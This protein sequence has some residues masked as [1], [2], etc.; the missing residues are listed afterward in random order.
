MLKRIITKALLLIAVAMTSTTANA[1]LSDILS[2]V[3]SAT[4]ST[5]SSTSSTSSS[6][7]SSTLSTLASIISSKLVPSSSQIVG[8]WVYKEPAIMFTS[9]S[10]LKS[11]ASSL[12][13]ST[14]EDK[15]QTQLSK[16]GISAGNCSITFNSDKSFTINRSSKQVASGT[17]TLSDDDV[18]L[19]FKGKSSASSITPQLD[20]GSLVLVTDV[21]NV[22]EAFESFGSNISQ[23]STL[24]SLSKSMDG[25]K[26]GLRMEKQ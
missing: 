26:V 14:I 3:K 7:S 15:L 25:M 2:K 5:S 21:S 24:T 4:S 13:T 19:T 17:Y 9:S 16:A 6:S 20:N 11:T 10:S 23:L 22:K 8:T 12:A 1:Q 18:Q